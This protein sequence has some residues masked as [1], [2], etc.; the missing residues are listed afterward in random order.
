VTSEGNRALARSDINSQI[1]K[2]HDNKPPRKTEPDTSHEVK[3]VIA[4]KKYT[5]KCLNCDFE[6]VSHSGFLAILF[7]AE[8]HGR[9]TEL[10][11][12]EEHKKVVKSW[13][14]PIREGRITREMLPSTSSPATYRVS[15]AAHHATTV[16]PSFSTLDALL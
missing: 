2:G 5:A 12:S 10:E 13:I 1:E 15:F 7:D 16:Y 8:D 14:G 6:S 3:I 9:I 4:R 11:G